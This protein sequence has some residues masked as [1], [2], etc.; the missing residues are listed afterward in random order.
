MACGKEK[1]TAPAGKGKGKGKV[2]PFGKKPK[3]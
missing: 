2:P 1:P 3:K